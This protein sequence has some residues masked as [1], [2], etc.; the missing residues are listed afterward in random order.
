MYPAS[1]IT[2]TADSRKIDREM[3]LGDT[4]YSL[5]RQEQNFIQNIYWLKE[6]TINF[7]LGAIRLITIHANSL[8]MWVLICL[9]SVNYVPLAVG[10]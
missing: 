9:L 2:N 6:K 5:A 3:R 8:L 1:Y 7:N 10:N 4:K